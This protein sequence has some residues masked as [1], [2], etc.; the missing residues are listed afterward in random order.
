MNIPFRIQKHFCTNWKTFDPENYFKNRL[1]NVYNMV[2]ENEKKNVS[3][4]LKWRGAREPKL[5]NWLQ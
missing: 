1:G 5:K 4:C 3:P 2:N